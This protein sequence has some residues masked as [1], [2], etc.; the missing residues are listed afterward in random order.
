MSMVTSQW[1]H[2]YRSSHNEPDGGY[3][4][5]EKKVQKLWPELVDNKYIGHVS[6][7]IT[8]PKK[9][10]IIQ[11]EADECAQCASGETK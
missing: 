6:K 8:P 3:L 10:L 1:P 11:K 9:R 5:D 4:Y 7:K 2:R